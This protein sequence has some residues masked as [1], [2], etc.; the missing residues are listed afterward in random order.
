VQVDGGSGDAPFA[1]LANELEKSATARA[2]WSRYH[3]IGDLLRGELPHGVSVDVRDRVTA[4]L[5]SEPVILAPGRL[6]RWGE[7]LLQPA[8]GVAV[9]ASVALAVVFGVQHLQQQSPAV[10]SVVAQRAPNESVPLASATPAVDG[11]RMNGTRWAQAQP[12]VERRLAGYLVYH[13]QRTTGVGVQAMV[14]SVQ[15]VGYDD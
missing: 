13:S 10:G 7:A 5:A 4:A 3:L 6:R 11:V 1:S 14:P 8:A 12:E 15:V 9:A 2:V